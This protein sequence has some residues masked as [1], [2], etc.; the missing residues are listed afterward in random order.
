M[1]ERVRGKGR[2]GNPLYLVIIFRFEK[3]VNYFG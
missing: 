3:I 1:R 2:G